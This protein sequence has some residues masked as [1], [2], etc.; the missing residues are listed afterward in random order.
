M[1]HTI[2]FVDTFIAVGVRLSYKPAPFAIPLHV[3]IHV[4]KARGLMRVD[5]LGVREVC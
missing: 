4:Q 2:C 3:F 1:S 5:Q